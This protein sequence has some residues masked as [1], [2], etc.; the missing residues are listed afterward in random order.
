MKIIFVLLLISIILIGGCIYSSSETATSWDMAREKQDYTLCD[1]LNNQKYVDGCY[2][3]IAIEKQEVAICEKIGYQS[4]WLNQATSHNSSYRENCFRDLAIK[5]KNSSLCEKINDRYYRG[6]CYASVAVEIQDSTLCTKIYYQNDA[7]WCYSS[8]AIKMQNPDLC[9]KAFGAERNKCFHFI[10]NIKQDPWLCEKIDGPTDKY[11][12]NYNYKDYCYVVL[13]ANTQNSEL[14]NKINTQE[15]KMDCQSEIFIYAKMSEQPT[16]E[17]KIKIPC[18]EKTIQYEKDM[19][20][21]IE[22]EKN[23][24]G[25]MWFCNMIISESYK[26][27]CYGNVEQATKKYK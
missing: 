5:T 15:G 18:E 7:S 13:A 16:T 8:V 22:A 14:C 6:M 21:R 12:K 11:F 25:F 20:L 1:K 2:W 3:D 19:C 17:E 23:I 4:Y 26:D 24:V 10:A 9:E 27:F